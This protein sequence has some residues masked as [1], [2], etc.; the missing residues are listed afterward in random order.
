MLNNM[1][2]LICILLPA[3]FITMLHL[4]KIFLMEEKYNIIEIIWYYLKALIII[5]IVMILIVLIVYRVWIWD[6]SIT[7]QFIIKYVLCGTV[8]SLFLP[9][10]YYNFRCIM[11]KNKT[12]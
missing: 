6:Y 2:L 11:L 3:I 12:K 8:F 9:Y 4:L 10:I 5:N 7:S 1:D